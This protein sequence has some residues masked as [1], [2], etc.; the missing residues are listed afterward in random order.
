MFYFAILEFFQSM[1]F[2]KKNKIYLFR[3]VDLEKT[4]AESINMMADLN[5]ENDK[6]QAQTK[7]D[8]ERLEVDVPYS[9]A[10]SL[11]LLCYNLLICQQ[12]TH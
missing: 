5:I 1:V 3:I 2:F 12:P 6:L 7:V 11:Q 10:S 9:E 8:L 4:L